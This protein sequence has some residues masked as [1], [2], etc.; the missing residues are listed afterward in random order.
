MTLRSSPGAQARS[1][2]VEFVGSDGIHLRAD[3]WSAPRPDTRPETVLLLHGGGQTRRSWHATGYRLAVAGWD[4]VAV[5][6][7]GHG[8]SEWAV[9]GGYSLDA[10]VADVYAIAETLP[11]PIVLVG[12]SLGGMAALVAEGEQPGLASA[13]VLVDVVPRPNEAGR[14]RIRAFMASA[15]D[16]FADLEEVVEALQTYNPHRPHPRSLDGLRKNLRR[17]VDGR[18]YWHWDPRFLEFGDEPTRGADVIRLFQAARRI[19]VPT[20]LIRGSESD[21]VTLDGARELLE[22]IPHAGAVEVQAGHMVAG[23]DND[24]FTTELVGFLAAAHRAATDA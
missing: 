24:V 2:E 11:R 3:K 9:A 15:P 18:W 22:I 14:A 4:A 16:G 5:D 7:R 17:R 21:V 20:L 12:A 6:A 1:T 19:S 8:D 10:F 13:L 23:D